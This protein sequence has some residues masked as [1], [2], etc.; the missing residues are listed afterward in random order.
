MV[1]LNRRELQRT[2]SFLTK[3][4]EKRAAIDKLRAAASDNP[5]AILQ[6]LALWLT[7]SSKDADFVD[8]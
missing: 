5:A 7:A 2:L 3:H 4:D 6:V 8:E 1:A